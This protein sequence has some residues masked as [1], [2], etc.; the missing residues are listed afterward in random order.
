MNIALTHMR[1]PLD[2]ALPFQAPEIDLILGGHDHIIMEKFIN[3]ILVVKSGDNF[4]HI[5]TINIYKKG[6]KE[7]PQYLGNS[8]DFDT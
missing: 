8:F 6:A 5:R 1:V 2:E 7:S 4:K 3:N